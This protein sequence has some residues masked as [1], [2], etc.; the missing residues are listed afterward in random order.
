VLAAVEVELEA[1]AGHEETL[2]RLCQGLV[3][4]PRRQREV[5]HLVFYQELSLSESAVVMGVTIGI[6]RKHYERSKQRLREWLKQDKVIDEPGIGRKEN[7]GP[8]S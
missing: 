4:L 6:A 5:L 7:Q 2:A 1:T 3:T 8:V